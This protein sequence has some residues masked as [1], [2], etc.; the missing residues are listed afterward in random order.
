MDSTRREFLRSSAVAG[1]MIGLGAIGHMAMAEADKSQAPSN[2]SMKKKTMLILGG[3]G[4]LGP[5]LV[6]S[7]KKAGYTITL[8]NRG[9]S[10]PDLFPELETLIGDREKKELDAL[11]N[12]KWDVC[13]DTWSF[14]PNVIED[15]T[16]ILKDTVEHYTFISTISVYSDNSIVNMDE[17][18]PLATIPEG[19]EDIYQWKYYGPLKV[20]DEQAAEKAFPGKTLVIRPGLIVGPRDRSDRFTYWPVR[21]ERGGEV[22]APGNP[23]DPVQYIDVRDLSNF[24]IKAIDER[25]TG[26]FNATGPVNPTT[27]AELLYGCKAVTGGDA[28][29]TWV[30]AEFLEEHGVRAWMDLPVWV[31]PVGES[32]GFSTIN[33]Q[34]AIAAG[35]T[36]RPLAETVE[37]TLEWWH[38][39]SENARHGLAP[40]TQWNVREEGKAPRRA[41]LPAAKEREVLEKWHARE[42]E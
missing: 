42:S 25:L 21:I 32:A 15:A 8:F 18:G 37:D 38:A 28:T 16:A 20:L 6:E 40:D 41:G 5:H 35:M 10:G 23:S 27:I 4:F 3:T 9:K 30:P 19:E 11:K 13:I 31:P 36:T 2:E 14:G 34:R 7:A 24:T 26:P 39:L 29:F 1:S 22:L 33:C 12:R 17:S